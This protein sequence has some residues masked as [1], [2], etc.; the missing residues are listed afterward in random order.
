M[1]P[2][3]RAE[4]LSVA[5]EQL[6]N[7]V[8]RLMTAE[9]WQQLITSRAWLRRYSLNNVIMI[10]QQCPEATDVR[11]LSEWKQEGHGYMRK[12]THKIKIWKP[13]LRTLD[14]EKAGNGG[15]S[16]NSPDQT[17]GTTE[18]SGFLLVPVV[19]VSQLQGE[20]RAN[21]PA[22]PRPIELSGDAP[23]GLWDL[24]AAQ[25][26]ARGYSV[27]RG[28]C[29][30]A[31]GR[32]IWG[33]RRVIVR[34]DVDP[35]QASK[36]LTHELAHILCEHETRGADTPRH[37]REVEAE[38]VA[39]VVA[40][41]CGLDTLAYS[42][43]YV[44]GWAADRDAARQSAQRVLTVADAILGRLDQAPH[45]AAST[46]ADTSAANAAHRNVRTEAA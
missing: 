36:T 2:E 12:G 18:L 14:P 1:S 34:A 41:V 24:I 45:Q 32:T 28:D 22:P 38:S 15:D 40:A 30:G 29:D 37:L 17:T 5:R 6:L 33:E 42:V 3:A 11:P 8:D 35:A 39:C 26:T 16:T 19:D 44:A 13:R 4:R 25:I 9:G 23:A 10:L 21:R 20:P 7:G 43:P 46:D 31:Y 27:E